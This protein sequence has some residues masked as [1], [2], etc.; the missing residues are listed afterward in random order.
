VKRKDNSTK[1]GKND[2]A[3]G[4]KIAHGAVVFFEKFARGGEND[5]FDH[6]YLK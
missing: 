2:P 5:G 4:K 3:A 6:I 1:P